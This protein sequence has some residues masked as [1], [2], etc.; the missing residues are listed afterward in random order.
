MKIQKLSTAVVV[1][2]IAT[3]ILLTATTIG[4]LSTTQEVPFEGT[5]TTLNVGVFLDPDCAQN[6]TSMS[7]GGVYAGDTENKKIYVKN[8]GNAPIELSMTISDWEPESANGPISMT[9]NK[10]NYV[11][12]P[13]QVIEATLTLTILENTDGISDFGYKMLITGTN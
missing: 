5:I 3:G 6:C 2:I 11:L 10:E 8:T 4:L 7:W 13:E 1:A 9:W 12:E